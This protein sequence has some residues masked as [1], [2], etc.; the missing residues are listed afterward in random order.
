MITKR[1]PRILLQSPGLQ[2]IATAVRNAIVLGRFDIAALKSARH[3]EVEKPPVETLG[4]F[5]ENTMKSQW[6]A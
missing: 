3:A 2:T 4:D 1:H 5:F 6:K